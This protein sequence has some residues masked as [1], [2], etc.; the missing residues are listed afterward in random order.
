MNDPNRLGPVFL[1]GAGP[2]DPGLLTLRG[3]ELLGNC[4]IVLYDGLSNP[5]LLAHAPQADHICV[6][7]HGKSRIWKQTEII[8]EMI[9]H[10]QSGK[11]VARLKG[12]DPAVFA[13][14]SEEVEALRAEGIRYEIVPGITAALAAGSYA[15]IPITDRK[16]ASAV[17]LVTGHEEPDKS[18]SAIDWEALAKFPGTL[19]IYMGV[20]TVG[21]WT[22][23][24]LQAGKSPDTPA[25][26]IRRCSHP[27]QQTI[28]CRLDEVADRLTPA[29]RFRPPVI[30]I[31]GPVTRLAETMSW[32]ERRHL[33]GQTVLVT[34]PIDQADALAGPLRERGA[35]VEI[36]P[37]IEIAPL[38]DNGPLDDVIKRVSDFDV[39]V[40][41]S[42]NGVTSFLDRLIQT[43][44]DVRVLAGVELAAVGSQTAEAIT[45]YHLRV[46]RVPE[47]F[48][49]ASL[50][51]MLAPTADGKRFLSIRASRGGTDLADGLRQAGGEV[52]EVIAYQHRDVVEPYTAVKEKLRAGLIDW[53]T[54]TSSAAANN[55][56][57]MF[58]N[59]LSL[60]RIASL[61]PVT[62]QTLQSLGCSVSVEADPHTMSGLVDAI[63]SVPHPER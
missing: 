56:F 17:A 51:K 24:L 28:H 3:A 5:D 47:D 32:V 12:G 38:D 13:R 40:F 14:T 1:I 10:A 57:R 27:D 15:G 39:I 7:K 61:S 34:R 60:A 43:E 23:A 6:G 25:A 48:R 42:R 35:H 26:L 62:T 63:S 31:L 33:H 20:T 54:V 19:V 4:D 11:S 9:R 30:V 46:D 8:A 59:D 41:S 58:G 18:E 29:S 21:S 2:G 52:T 16:L 37:A 49:A 55:L 36:Q 45:N 22:D 53:V 44:G 50:A